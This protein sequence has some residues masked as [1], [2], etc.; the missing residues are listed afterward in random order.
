MVDK[1]DNL[2]EIWEAFIDLQDK[3]S[4]RAFVFNV[5]KKIVNDLAKGVLKNEKI[6]GFKYCPCRIPSGNKEEDLKL[7]CPCNF[8]THKTWKDRGE[9]WCSLFVKR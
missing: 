1:I 6:H 7:I 2:I 3:K 4:N 5:D 9:C 8:W